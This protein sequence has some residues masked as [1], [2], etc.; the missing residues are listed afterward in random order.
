MKKDDPYIIID[1]WDFHGFS[2]QKTD[3]DIVKS[4]LMGTH[5]RIR[6]KG[7]LEVETSWGIEKFFGGDKL[8]AVDVASIV[9]HLRK[10]SKNPLND[11]SK[12][13]IC[14]DLITSVLIHELSHW[15]EEIYRPD[16]EHSKRWD[17][18]Y[19]EKI[20]PD[21]SEFCTKRKEGSK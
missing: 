15:A 20:Y 8:V 13:I 1:A 3:L 5:I 6:E 18:F 11:D 4:G 2:I 9:S 21:V 12:A 16:R 17:S 19:Y 14:A 7:E 10:L